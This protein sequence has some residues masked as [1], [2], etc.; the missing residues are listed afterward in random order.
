MPLDFAYLDM[1]RATIPPAI[2]ITSTIAKG[3]HV[4]AN[5]HHQLHEITPQSLRMINA[6]VRIE[7]SPG[8]L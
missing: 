6:T 7:Q 5:T 1:H 2:R 4:G 8:P 3:I